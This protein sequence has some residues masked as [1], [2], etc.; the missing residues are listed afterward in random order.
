[1]ACYWPSSSVCKI[2]EI[3][4]DA[5]IIVDLIDCRKFPNALYSFLLADCRSLLDRIPRTKVKHVYQ[6]VN[7]CV[8]VL[9][10]K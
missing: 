9:A 5:K 6:E 10:R 4:L 7:R 8:D 2:L 1:M 3:E